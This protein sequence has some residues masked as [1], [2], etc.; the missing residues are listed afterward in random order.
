MFVNSGSEAN[1]VA[2]RMATALSGGKGG[3]TLDGGYHGITRAISDFTPSS[4]RSATLPD[5]MRLIAPPDDYR[6]LYDPKKYL[7]VIEQQ[8]DELVE[9]CGFGGTMIDPF[10]MSNGVLVPPIGYL[11]NIAALVRR[12]GGFYIADEVQAGFGRTGEAFWGFQYHQVE[13]DFITIGKPAGNGHPIGAILTKREHLEKFQRYTSFFSTF[14]GNNVSAAI[15]KAVIDTIFRDK[16]IENSKRMGKIFKEGLEKLKEK[17]PLIVGDVRGIGLGMGIEIV[18]D[19]KQ[20]AKVECEQFLILL[21]EA[22]VLCGA[23][24][25]LGNVCKIRPPLI[26]TEDNVRQA[27]EG[28]DAALKQMK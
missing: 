12:K 21:K 16:L 1:D 25:Q 13:P 8:I 18:K 24:G 15:G 22:G 26:F 7:E 14:G 2:W 6:H 5:Y 10:F 4:Y 11:R 20:P 3:L 9:S 17:Y 27:L 23:D 19:G 28:F